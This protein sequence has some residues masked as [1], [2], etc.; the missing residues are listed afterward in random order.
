MKT[1]KEIKPMSGY[2][3]LFFALIALVGGIY[4]VT[5]QSFLIGIGVALLLTMLILLI[6]LFFLNPNKAMVLTLF[7][8]YKGTVKENGFYWVNPF[9]A[10]KPI[11]LRAKN[12][13]STPIKVNDKLG[14]PIMIGAIV[15][16][17]VLDTYKASFEVDNFENFVQVQTEAA[18]RHLAGVYPYDNIEEWEHEVTLRSGVAEVNQALEKE[19]EERLKIAGIEVI[20]ARISHLAYAQEIAGAM[21]KRQQAMAIIAARQK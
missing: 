9:L 3:T 10:K 18:I 16:W 7:G 12:F 20:E 8:E 21:L 14:N 13:D 6:G 17:R 19:I 4:F 11:T 15:V 5:Q 2:P 1:E